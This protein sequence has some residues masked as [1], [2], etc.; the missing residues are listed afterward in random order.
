MSGRRALCALV[1]AA[2]LSGGAV[3]PVAS[4]QEPPTGPTGPPTGE[5]D[6]ARRGYDEALA[7]EEAVLA[8]YEAATRRVSELGAEAAELDA[9]VASAEAEVA[10]AEADLDDALDELASA[11]R[12]ADA[13]ARDLAEAEEV[14]R[15]QA[16]A[17]YVNGMEPMAVAGALLRADGLGELES[18]RTYAEVIAN[19]QRDAVDAYRAAE[20]RAEEEA[21]ARQAAGVRA[22]AV[23]DELAERARDLDEARAALA[24]VQAEAG[25]EAARQ[26]RLL[27]EVQARRGAYEQRVAELEAE[28]ARIEALLREQASASAAAAAAAAAAGSPSTDAGPAPPADTGAALGNP[29]SRMVVT[30]GFGYRIHPIYGTTRLHAGIDLDGDTG[31]TVFAAGSGTVVFAGGRGGYGNCVIV[32]HGGGMATLY[33]HLDSIAVR[34][35]TSVVQGQRVGAVGSTGASTGPHLHFEVRIDGIPVNPVPYLP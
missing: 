14:L 18:S 6:E 26:Q 9:R 16:V 22:E 23:R 3:A 34:S 8:A 21:D 10:E 24:S 32:D 1:C 19:R 20:L 29:L 12:R 17:A 30:S 31:D 35:G 4:G 13:A 5:L 28:S 2:V 27:A 33:A 15:S 7:E 25:A 11:E